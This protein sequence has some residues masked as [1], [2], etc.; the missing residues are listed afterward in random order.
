VGSCWGMVGRLAMPEQLGAC[1]LQN[2]GGTDLERLGN[3]DYLSNKQK[4]V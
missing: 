4:E 1:R 3:G 2:R